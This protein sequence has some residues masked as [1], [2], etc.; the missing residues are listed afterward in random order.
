MNGPIRR[1]AMALFVAMAVLVGMVTWVQV[2]DAAR[3]R[4]DPRNARVVAARVG[5]ERGPI[6]TS[7]G[8]VV[9][10]S[11]PDPADRTVFRRSYPQGPLYAHLVGY[12]TVLFGNTGL[13]ESRSDDL[14]SDRDSTIS[15]VLNAMLG[16]DLRP[17]GLRLTIDNDLQTT[18]VAALGTLRGAVVAL[19]PETGGILAMVSYPSFNPNRLIGSDAAA[20]GEAIERHPSQPLLNRATDTTYNPGSTFKTVVTAAGLGGGTVDP[21]TTFPDPTELPLPGST[22]T[23]SNY[24]GGPCADGDEV[25]LAQAFAL[26]CNTTFAQLGMDLGASAVVGQAE[27]FGFNR[28]IESEVPAVE[29][30]IPSADE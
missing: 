22:A 14:V 7:D 26:S 5:R 9:A 25:A 3:Y 24:S 15:G 1:M 13:E 23:I 19:D 21:E 4:D 8:V 28:D 2:V 30:V 10:Q 17:H 18:A 29:S 6:I 12:S 20:A 16:G 11:L 27:A